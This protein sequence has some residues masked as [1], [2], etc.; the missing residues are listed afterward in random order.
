M[1]SVSLHLNMIPNEY[2]KPPV[3]VR[4]FEIGTLAVPDNLI[5]M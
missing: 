5:Q 3:W 1:G 4:G 2:Q